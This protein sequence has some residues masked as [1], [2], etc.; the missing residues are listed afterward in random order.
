MPY[1]I[2]KIPVLDLTGVEKRVQDLQVMVASLDWLEYSFGLSRK[3]NLGT[4]DEI[5]APVVYTGSDPLDVRIWPS[6]VYKAYSFWLLTE[7]SEFLYHDNVNARRRYPRIEQPLAVIVCIDLE[8]VSRG[9]AYP[10]TISNCK[11]EFINKVNNNNI[12]NGL[13]QVASVTDDAVKVFD[14]YDVTETREPH[15]C[16]RVEGL[17]TYTHDCN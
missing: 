13:F 17:L 2:P 12:S 1:K 9:Q 5:I 16:F 7:P 6:D 11:N 15:Y 8:K 4:E 10:V 3:V 14:E